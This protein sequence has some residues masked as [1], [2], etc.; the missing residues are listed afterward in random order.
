MHLF[1]YLS[2]WYTVY[3]SYRTIA[4]LCSFRVANALAK[5]SSVIATIYK[6][7]YHM[8][9]NFFTFASKQTS[10][11]L[12]PQANYT[13][14]ATDTC[15]QNLVS[16]FVERGVSRDQRGGSPTVVNL[17]FLDRSRYFSFK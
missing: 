11:A 10:G 5:S 7:I 2:Y 14:W 4:S 17:S 1:L 8:N 3:V 12:S 9:T 13:E 6:Y 15:R 16:T